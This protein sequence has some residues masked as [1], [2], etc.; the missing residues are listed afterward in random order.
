[1]AQASAKTRGA[2]LCNSNFY[3]IKGCQDPTSWEFYKCTTLTNFRLNAEALSDTFKTVIVAG[4]DTVVSEAKTQVDLETLYDD[5]ACIVD[6]LVKKN[7]AVT[8]GPIVPWKTFSQSCKEACK[9]A[10]VRLRD[11]FPSVNVMEA[12][13]RLTYDNDGIHLTEAS[14][15]KLL[16]RVLK[17]ATGGQKATQDETEDEA[18]DQDFFSTP[19]TSAIKGKQGLK[20][21]TI[22][23]PD[24]QGL[25]SLTREVKKLKQEVDERRVLDYMVFARHQEELDQLKNDKNLHK[26]VMYGVEVPDVFKISKGPARDQ[27]LKTKVME[28]FKEIDNEFMKIKQAG[29]GAGTDDE[30]EIQIEEC[31]INVKITFIRHLN[32]HLENQNPARQILEVRLRDPKEA[33][34]IK[35]RFGQLSKA[36]RLARRTPAY[37]SGLSITN[38][39]TKETRVRVDVMQ[40]LVKLIKA[41]SNMD[42]FVIQHISKPLMKVIEKFDN[43]S[44]TRSYN[45]TESIAFFHS[46]FPGKLCDQDLIAAYNKAGSK[47]GPEIS[48]YFVVLKG[49]DHPFKP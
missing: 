7:C 35:R 46:R 10:M 37:F 9:A 43:G 22:A 47:Y 17:K 13:G 14:A 20:R 25:A 16:E 5:F 8:V 3:R 40:A 26:I 30:E 48:H 41:N 24:H 29:A 15:K 19:L 42:A 11:N 34:L 44:R 39:V 38:C 2:I 32:S 33:G 21:K 49:K 18:M 36:W 31:A 1:M 23:S 4:L 6:I 12:P 45:Y 27:A 28:I